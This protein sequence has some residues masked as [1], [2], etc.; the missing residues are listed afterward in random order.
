M[1]GLDWLLTE[2][3][4]LEVAVVIPGRRLQQYHH[5]SERFGNAAFS[6]FWS[7]SFLRKKKKMM[8]MTL[9]YLAKQSTVTNDNQS[10][11]Q[12]ILFECNKR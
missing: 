4:V 6:P 12:K 2:V 1:F 9:V 11:A 10:A 3:S 7:L 8:M 5:R